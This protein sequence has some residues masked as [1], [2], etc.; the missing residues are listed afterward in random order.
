MRVHCH[1]WLVLG[2]LASSPAWAKKVDLDY[3]VRLLPQS[4]QAEVRLTLADGATVRSLDFDLGKDGAY[5]D[6]QADG[7]WQVQG[8]DQRGHWQ[9]AP[10]K[11]QL[12]YKVHL[13]QRLKGG[14]YETRM[15]PDW[16]LFRG[17]DLV[18]PARLDQHDG[19]ELVAR[20]SF[21]LPKGWKSVET[22]WP[23]IGKN[24]FRIDN[25]S[26]L[27]DRPTGWML[28]G[29][30]GTRRARL[31]ET[32]VSVAAPQGQAMRRLDN[33]TLLTFVWPQ[34]QAVFPRNP[35]KLLLVG[36]RDEL[37]R[38]VRAGH[39]SIYLHSSRPLVG[40]NGSSPVLRELVHVFA[41]INDR[42]DSDWIGESLAEY[43]ASELLRRAG[44][45]TEERYQAQ[46]AS[47]ERSGKKV[48]SLR[49]EQVDSAV[50]AR[51]VLLLRA[52]D[53]EIR[54]HTHNQRSLDDVTRAMMRLNSV[55]TEEF[56]QLSESVLGRSSEVLQSKLLR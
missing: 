3:H 2:L 48:S 9:P 27:F 41:Q 33:L 23:R 13:S 29:T 38:G 7:Q 16:A 42:Q 21:E 19:T 56:I 25:V 54:L 15:T 47:L 4:E 24:R 49:G 55:S 36:A 17:D 52:L 34:L 53:Q 18:P 28:A 22:P 51:G 1:W 35:P 20:L 40:E 46:Q 6:F 44:G 12:T 8:D 31:G 43:Y 26:R 50:I 10:G 14:A 5:S 45:M 32:E 11:S 39:N 37:W 30:I